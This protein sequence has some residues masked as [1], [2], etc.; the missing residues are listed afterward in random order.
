M[1]AEFQAPRSILI[2]GSGVFGLSTAYSLATNDNF[3][4]TKIT[5]VD[6]AEF[7]AKDGG[8]IDQSRLV[9]SDYGDQAYAQL[10][11]E[12]KHHWRNTWWGEN[13]YQEPGVV[14]AKPDD[15]HIVTLTDGF[16][17][18]YL[19]KWFE[20]GEKLGLKIGT[21]EEGGTLQKLLNRDAI[22][23]VYK[24]PPGQEHSDR[25]CH[26]EDGYANWEAGWA[27]AE[28]AMRNLRAKVEQ[29]NRVDF[30]YGE[31]KRLKFDKTDQDQHTVTGA[32][33]A[34][35]QELSADLTVMATGSWSATLLDMRGIGNATGQ[36]LAYMNVTDE[37]QATMANNPTIIDMSTLN[38]LVPPNNN[39]IR[40]AQHAYGYANFTTIPY[41]EPI[42]SYEADKSA[43]TARDTA[44]PE[45]SPAPAPPETYTVS[46]PWTA[47]NDPD[48][49]IPAEEYKSHLAYLHE[50]YPCL[51]DRKRFDRVRLCWYLDTPSE[52][53]VVS[54]HPRYSHPSSPASETR[55]GLFVAT[56]GSGHAFKFLPV[57]GDKIVAAVMGSLDPL[58]ANKWAWPRAR[59]E[60]GDVWSCNW[61]GGRR[62][63]HLAEELAKA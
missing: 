18:N 55:K 24:Q 1:T 54:Y 44:S 62:G 47:R 13:A 59:K 41:P 60:E 8:S 35:G 34:S 48:L 57:L 46:L 51:R 11:R 39:V 3:N 27:Y 31:I 30:V 45:I 36:I 61:R 42:N 29:L 19:W 7:P 21:K 5:L 40:T 14:L 37:E 25:L 9:R 38:F 20:S 23:A 16:D 43:T 10:A 52:D 22:K 50:I 28:K 26:F 32:V 56:G 63:M 33:L 12:A 17:P 53:F 2:L 49:K 4:D 15:S 6:R 58:Y